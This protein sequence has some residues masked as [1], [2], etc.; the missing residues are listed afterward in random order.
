MT[1]AELKAQ[2]YRDTGYPS[3]PPT[4]VATRTGAWINEGHRHIL[5]QPSMV[6]LRQGTLTFASVASQPIYGLPQAFEKMDAIMQ[7][8]NSLR[9]RMLTRDQYRLVD[10]GERSN[11][12]P[13]AWVPVGLVPVFQQPA[14]TGLWAVSSSA[15]DTTPVVTVT[16]ILADGDIPAQVQV[17]LNG[18]TRAQLGSNTTWSTIMSWSVSAACVGDVSIYDAASSGNLLARIP[19]GSTSV[20]YQGIRLWPTPGAVL[21]YTVDGQFE[22]PTLVN[23]NDVPLVPPSYHDLLSCYARSREY[24]RTED[25]RYATAKAEFDEGVNRLRAFVEFPADWHPVT[26]G[27]LRATRWNNLNSWCPADGWGRP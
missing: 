8:T 10:P 27:T 13:Y 12:T 20:Q 9:L 6:N 26:G 22:I 5:R 1:F 18:T 16:G 24:E 11:G 25:P 14:S 19:V 21:T 4:D 15:S 2:V 3:S 7:Q 17:T 23:D